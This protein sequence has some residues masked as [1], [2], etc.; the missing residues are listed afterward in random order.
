VTTALLVLG[1]VVATVVVV[2][3][4]LAATNPSSRYERWKRRHFRNLEP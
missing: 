3:W 4:N 1:A 2:I